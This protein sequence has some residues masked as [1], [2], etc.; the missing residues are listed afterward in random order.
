MITHLSSKIGFSFKTCTLIENSFM[1][2]RLN[3]L[4]LYARGDAYRE[5]SDLN[6]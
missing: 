3:T 4:L 1:L 5:N 6:L 2:P